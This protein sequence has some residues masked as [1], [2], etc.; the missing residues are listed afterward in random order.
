M[1]LDQDEDFARGA[2]LYAIG[3]YWDAHE[4]WEV[5]WRRTEDDDTRVF[6][7][8]LIQVTAAL[9]KLYEKQD[10]AAAERL[11]RKAVEKLDTLPPV[12]H[13]VSVAGFVESATVCRDVLEHDRDKNQGGLRECRI[14][15]LSFLDS[16]DPSE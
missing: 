15:A 2:K 1:R 7:Q 10:R 3:R 11:F 5:L 12:V 16:S 8:G 4:A 9:Y 14:P 13:G 6:V